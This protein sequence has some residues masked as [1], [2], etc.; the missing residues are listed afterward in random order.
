MNWISNTI[1]QKGHLEAGIG[2]NGVF[3]AETAERLVGCDRIL[4]IQCV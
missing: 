1:L 2:W 3:G 4:L